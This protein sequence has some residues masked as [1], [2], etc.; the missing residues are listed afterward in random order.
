MLS[1][2]AIGIGRT[3]EARPPARVVFPLHGIRTVGLW[4]DAFHG[5]AFKRGWNVRLSPWHFGKFGTLLFLMSPA[6]MRKLRWFRDTYQTEMKHRD[7]G[8]S[9][10]ELPSVVAHSFGTYILGHALLQYPFIRFN[11]VLLCGSILPRDFPWKA[12]I[13]RGQVQ[14]VRNEYGV[15]DVWARIVA[16]FVRGSGSSGVKGFVIEPDDRFEQAE[17]QYPHSEYFSDGHIEHCWFPFLERP[18]AEIPYVERSV[19]IPRFNR[20]WALYTLTITPLL[21]IALLNRPS[22]S[23]PNGLGQLSS[24]DPPVTQGSAISAKPAVPTTDTS[25]RAEPEKIAPPQSQSSEP[26]PRIKPDPVPRPQVATTKP[27]PQLVPAPAEPATIAPLQSKSSEPVQGTKPDALLRPQA[28]TTK[29]SPEQV[30]ATEPAEK[31]ILPASQFHN[32]AAAGKTEAVVDLI[33]RGTNV[34]ARSSDGRTALHVA[35]AAGQLNVVELLLRHRAD[36]NL[37]YT[38]SSTGG[39][40]GGS[41]S[42]GNT[43]LYAAAAAG[44][45]N[46]VKLLVNAGAKVETY[47]RR[48]TF[49][50]GS[51]L[52]SPLAAAAAHGHTSTVTV[53]LG[54][55]A[56]VDPPEHAGL[57][58]RRAHPLAGAVRNNHTEVAKLLLAKGAKPRDTEMQNAV[59]GGNT[60]LTKAL[61]EAGG[62]VFARG[63]NGQSLLTIA[64]EKN[65]QEL[66]QL[67]EGLGVQD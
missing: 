61:I 25:A 65:H 60:L 28:A 1:S 24:S 15:R 14:A 22:D 7:V 64:K 30:P 45:T 56:A 4:R 3:G 59:S 35:S 23:H 36:P 46:I 49:P 26:A 58:A 33:R 47:Q 54:Y 6:R 55:G 31:V 43:A 50:L 67:L 52:E 19:T 48:T 32:A 40:L 41:Q 2:D 42:T 5:V 62:D 44:H 57:F 20:P 53:L 16:W 34:D 38:S 63:E 51:I 66:A 17:F 29:L 8:L 10:G 21:V 37:A 11:K 18:L 13:G 9:E 39:F 27:S 12:L